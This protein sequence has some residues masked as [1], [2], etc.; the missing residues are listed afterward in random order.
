METVGKVVSRYEFSSE[1]H[2]ANWILKIHKNNILQLL[3][4]KKSKEYNFQFVDFNNWE[5]EA[6]EFGDDELEA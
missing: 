3:R 6:K 4:T 1:N 5:D 2:F